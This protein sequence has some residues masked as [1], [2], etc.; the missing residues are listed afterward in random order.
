MENE[1]ECL[2]K[3]FSIAVA[4]LIIYLA[5][6]GL[7]IRLTSIWV[8]SVPLIFVSLLLYDWFKGEE[9]FR[10]GLYI[11]VYM[12]IGGPVTIIGFFSSLWFLLKDIRDEEYE[13][14]IS[15]ERNG[16]TGYD[17][18]TKVRREQKD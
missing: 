16:D 5:I 15:K 18:H 9:M 10:R 4:S 3:G 17:E 1:T 2:V 7:D 6:Y 13:E 14:S 8:C 11:D 12:S